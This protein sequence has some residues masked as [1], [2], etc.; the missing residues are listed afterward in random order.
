MTDEAISGDMCPGYAYI[1][2]LRQRCESSLECVV[3]KHNTSTYTRIGL[4]LGPL[5][6]RMVY[7]FQ[8]QHRY[9]GYATKGVA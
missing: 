6:R 9:W 7:F 4:P 1:W 3:A 2:L 5:G 8:V